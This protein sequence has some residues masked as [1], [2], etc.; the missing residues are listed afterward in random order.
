VIG[1]AAYFIFRPKNKSAIDRFYISTQGQSDERVKSLN[2]DKPSEDASYILDTSKLTF[3][4]TKR[5][6]ENVDYKADPETDWI[7]NLVQVNGQTFDKKDLEKLFDKDWNTNFPSTIFGF[8][9]VDKR[10][11]YVF[12]GGVPDIYNKIQIA[13][14]VKGVYNEENPNYDPKKLDR[15]VIQ[16]ESIIKKYPTKLKIEQI[17]TISKAIGKAKNLVELYNEFNK[18]AIII[19]KSGK[20]FNGALAW[21]A[22]LSV[23]L[24]WGDGDLFHWTNNQDYG[25]DQHFSVWTTTD[26]GYFL[27]ENIQSGQM[28]PTDL[29]FGFSIPRSADP[30]N[31]YTAMLNSVKYCQ[32][33]LGGTILNKDEQPFQEQ[34]ETKYLLDLI[35][36]MKAK[37][38]EP[39]SDKA[40][41]NY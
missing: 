40:L 13:I 17:E 7:I 15:Y 14:N 26:P 35:D 27:P 1:I 8:S 38:I 9:P 28:N 11:T 31:V 32:K 18:D 34:T 20:P 2:L 4:K 10:W 19:L 29:I 37:G 23:G 6:T 21:D 3:P 36:K 16:L 39:G 22:L 24:R 12:A 30:K 33:R 5:E 25:H 41:K